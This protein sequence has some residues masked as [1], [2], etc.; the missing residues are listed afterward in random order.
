[1]IERHD[2]CDPHMPLWISWSN[3]MPFFI[4][5]HFIIM[6]LAPHQNNMPSTRWYC[7]DL[8]V[9]HSTS[10]LSSHGGWFSRNI[11]IGCIQSYADSCSSTLMTI[12]SCSIAWLVNS[13]DLTKGL[14]SFS[15][16]MSDRVGALEE[17]IYAR[18]SA[19]WLS[20][21]GIYHTSNPS[22]N[23]SIS[24]SSARYSAIFSLLQS[25][26]FLTC[27]TTS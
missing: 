2:E 8:C 25:Y 5:I 15:I 14:D 3:S 19:S 17:V 4:D 20:R 10:T 22:K 16:M 6:P 12:R 23:F 11:L 27:F 24:Y 7:V 1:M 13:A 9:I 26:S 21:C 18:W